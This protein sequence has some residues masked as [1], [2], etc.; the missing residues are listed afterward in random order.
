[1]AVWGFP[2]CWGFEGCIYEFV[3]SSLS[4]VGWPINFHKVLL[5]VNKI[6]CCGQF[7]LLFIYLDNKQKQTRTRTK[8]TNKYVV[9]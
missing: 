5:S 9:V 6:Y 1:M 3:S 2:G 7:F 4:V 8:E